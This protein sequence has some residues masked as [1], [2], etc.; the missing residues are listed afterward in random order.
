MTNDVILEVREVS[1]DFSGFVALDKVSLQVE[2]RSMTA[3]VGP[4]GAGKTTLL[5]CMSGMYKPTGGS[6]LYAGARIDGL[7]PHQTTGRGIGRTF[8]NVE[9][10]RALTPLELGLLGRHQAFRSRLL[11]ETLGLPASRRDEA[12]QAELVRAVMGRVGILDY[13]DVRLER[14][15]YSVRKMADLARALCGKPD[16]LLLDEPTAGMGSTD[17]A[18]LVEFLRSARGELYETMVLID[19]DIDFVRALCE[20]TIV[21]DFGRLIAQGPSREVFEDARVMSAYLG[22]APDTAAR[23]DN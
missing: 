12:S 4:N 3:I 1:M 6:I 5:N 14:L 23:T 11:G 18:T 7:R 10:F 16:V 19:H 22:I 17:K 8:Q 9:Q 2:R 21:L 15:P 13:A 20:T